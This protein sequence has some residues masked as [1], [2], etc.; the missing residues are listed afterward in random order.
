MPISVDFDGV[1]TRKSKKSGRSAP[2][3]TRPKKEED[4]EEEEEEE[5]K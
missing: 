4:E 3:G 5:E 2:K 1:E